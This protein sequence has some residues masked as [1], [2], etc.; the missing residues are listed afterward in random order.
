M[1]ASTTDRSTSCSKATT[2]T[3]KSWRNAPL[4]ARLSQWL[5]TITHTAFCIKCLW[6]F[7]WP[8]A[9]SMEGIST[10]QK[11]TRMRALI[12]GIVWIPREN[13][14]RTCRGSLVNQTTHNTST[15]G[16]CQRSIITGLATRI[17][18]SR[19]WPFAQRR[20]QD[21]ES[22]G[23]KGRPDKKV[24]GRHKMIK[25]AKLRHFS[26]HGLCCIFQ[27]WSIYEMTQTLHVFLNFEPIFTTITL[28]G[29]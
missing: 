9:Q 28:L 18:P 11:I 15:V 14:Q 8:V 4:K 3:R 19:E 24:K 12:I 1:K 23:A 7:G 27:N 29:F 25:Y 6:R 20:R 21:F 26:F 16:A 5:A 10:V 22:G 13:V 2:T 17:V